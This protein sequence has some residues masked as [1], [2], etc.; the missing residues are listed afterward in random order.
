MDAWIKELAPSTELRKWFH[1]DPAN[2]KEFEK[3]YAKELDENKAI[4][5]PLIQKYLADTL[6]LLYAARDPEINHARCLQA[7]LKKHV[8]KS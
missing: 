1:H 7:Y 6:T 5:M 3:R 2:F 8:A 4:W